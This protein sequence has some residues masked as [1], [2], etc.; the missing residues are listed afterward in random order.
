MGTYSLLDRI[1]GLFPGSPGPFGSP[2]RT[3][4]GGWEIIFIFRVRVAGFI[5]GLFLKGAR[6]EATLMD[7]V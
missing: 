4:G 2:S 5:I 6:E 1:V 3:S 7:G